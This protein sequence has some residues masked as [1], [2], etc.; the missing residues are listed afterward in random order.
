MFFGRGGGVRAG[1]ISSG[2]D[3]LKV[4]ELFKSKLFSRGLSYDGKFPHL[5]TAKY[6]CVRLAQHQEILFF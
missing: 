2:A 5:G 6:E 1:V 3:P 4:Y